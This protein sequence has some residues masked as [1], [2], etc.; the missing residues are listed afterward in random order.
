MTYIIVLKVTKFGE[1]Q[2]NRFRDIHKKHSGAILPA[3]IG[4]KNHC[5]KF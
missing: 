2:L 5:T 3:K 4:L 1:D